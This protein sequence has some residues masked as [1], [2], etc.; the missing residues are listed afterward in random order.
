VNY[1]KDSFEEMKKVT[2]PTRN[3]ALKITVITIIFT[4]I[5]TFVVTSLDLGF[6]TAYDKATDYSPKVQ[7]DRAEQAAQATAEQAA[8]VQIDPNMLNLTD[9]EGNPVNATV[10]P[11]TPAPA[12]N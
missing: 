5:A 8:P 4:T 12:A 9:S 7:R 1:F 11:T 10:T 6:K 3:H 2:W